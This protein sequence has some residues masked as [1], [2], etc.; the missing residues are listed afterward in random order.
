MDG[1]PFQFDQCFALN[2]GGIDKELSIPQ[3]SMTTSS[4][5][6]YVQQMRMCERFE[7]DFTF[8]HKLS[9]DYELMSVC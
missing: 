7:D 2:F 5:T 6:R 4:M 9:M 8:I 1:K 3:F